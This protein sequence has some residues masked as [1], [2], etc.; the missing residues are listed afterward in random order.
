MSE[1]LDTSAFAPN[2][3]FTFG[4]AAHN[5]IGGPPLFN[6]DLALCKT[7]HITEWLKLQIRAEAFKFTNLPFFAS[8]GATVGT[9]AFGQISSADTQRSLQFGLK[10]IF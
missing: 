5:L 3:A 1:W 6:M 2:A 9:P 10:A 7:A 8:P 4:N